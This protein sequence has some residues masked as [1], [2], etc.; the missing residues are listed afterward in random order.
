MGSGMRFLNITIPAWATIDTAQLIITAQSSQSGTTVKSRIRAEAN[1][2]PATFST[3]AN[4]DARTWTTALTNWDSIAAWTAETEYTS[5]NFKTSIQEVINLANWASGNPVVV[6]W[7]DFELRGTQSA[8]IYRN[9]YAYNSS[10]SKAAKLVITYTVP[11]ITGTVTLAGAGVIS[12]T[13]RAINQ[14]TNIAYTG[15]TIAD[16][17]YIVSAP[18]GTYHIVVEYETGGVKYNAKSLWGVA[19]S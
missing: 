10:T 13:V 8:N 3:L 5:P 16:G 2:N 6:L 19:V 1:I 9:G 17:T 14:S 15:T 4:F 7:D 11:L 12:A 18:A